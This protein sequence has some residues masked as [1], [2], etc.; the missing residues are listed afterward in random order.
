MTAMWNRIHK[1]L[2]W[3]LRR[4]G[5][6]GAERA[7][8]GTGVSADD[9]MSEAL[10]DLFQNAEPD[11]VRTWEGLAVTIAERRAKDALTKSQKGLRETTTGA[12]LTLVSGDDAVRHSGGDEATATTVFDA[13]RESALDGEAEYLA[14]HAAQAL[15]DLAREVLDERK[16]RVFLGWHYR[17]MSRKEL[18]AEL[19]LTPQRIGQIFVEALAVLKADPRFPYQ[20]DDKNRGEPNAEGS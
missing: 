19:G 12:R 20:A 1:V 16:Q 9:I 6:G 4:R 7:I 5:G 3:R 14:L 17:G 2:N 18:A 13:H 11:G 10:R 8:R 15:A